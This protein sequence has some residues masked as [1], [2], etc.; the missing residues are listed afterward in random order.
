MIYFVKPFERSSENINEE[1]LYRRG[2]RQGFSEAL[3]LFEE[4]KDIDKLKKELDSISN[5]S[6]S[7]FM[8]TG[9]SFNKSHSESELINIR[10]LEYINNKCLQNVTQEIKTAK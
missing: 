7:R 5:W 8:K 10:L 6:T 1:Y 4:L 9:N 2:Y 3:K